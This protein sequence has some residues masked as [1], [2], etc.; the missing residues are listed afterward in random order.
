MGSGS[1]KLRCDSRVQESRFRDDP[2]ASGTGDSDQPEGGMC[3]P[4]ARAR[5]L[6]ILRAADA[7]EARSSLFVV[8]QVTAV[9]LLDHPL[10]QATRWS[11]WT[12]WP[13]CL[14]SCL[15]FQCG[16]MSTV[17]AG[18]RAKSVVG[19]CGRLQVPLSLVHSTAKFTARGAK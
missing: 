2:A 15:D 13:A 8:D 1:R 9:G 14:A 7:T 10:A 6:P 17:A 3:G 19:G 12:P 4:G 11:P 16:R 5:R 18:H